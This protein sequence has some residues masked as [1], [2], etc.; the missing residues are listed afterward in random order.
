[1]TYDRYYIILRIQRY[2]S[3]ARASTGTPYEWMGPY[4]DLGIDFDN[5]I[6]IS[7]AHHCVAVERGFV[8]PGFPR[9]NQYTRASLISDGELCW[10]GS[11]PI[12]TTGSGRAPMDVLTGL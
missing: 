5:T 10:R 9:Q 1:M 12:P 11:R 7:R 8:P 4:R 6:G 2:N 3:L